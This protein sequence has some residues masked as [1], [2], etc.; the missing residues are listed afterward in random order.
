MS[1][2]FGTVVSLN[3]L[4]ALKAFYG[5]IF[6]YSLHES[7]S[8]LERLW[9]PRLS[10]WVEARALKTMAELLNDSGAKMTSVT[11][12]DVA[13]DFFSILYCVHNPQEVID[14]KTGKEL[15]RVL[16]NMTLEF[17]KIKKPRENITH[18]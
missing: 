3:N 2:T 1:L 11:L 5:F 10:A 15:F 13:S 14:I 9:L 7:P 8:F 16:A 12:N 18:G 4:L 17:E 6:N